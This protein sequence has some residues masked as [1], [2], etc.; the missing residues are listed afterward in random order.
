MHLPVAIPCG[1]RGRFNPG[2]IP[3]NSV[4]FANF[5]SQFLSRD[6]G[7]GPL[8]HFRGKKHGERPAGFVTSPPS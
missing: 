6:G 1:G 3:G 2:D 8:L 5:Y 4:G 7:S